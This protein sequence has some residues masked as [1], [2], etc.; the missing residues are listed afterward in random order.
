MALGAAAPIRDSSPMK[1]SPMMLSPMMVLS[2]AV[3]VSEIDIRVGDTTSIAIEEEAELSLEPGLILRKVEGGRA[4]IAA[5]LPGEFTIEAHSGGKT[6]SWRVVVASSVETGEVPRMHPLRR[7]PREETTP[8][9]FLWFLAV[10]GIVLA[11]LHR[12]APREDPRAEIQAKRRDPVD[13]S[14]GRDLRKLYA[15]MESALRDKERTAEVSRFLDH[16]QSVRFSRNP[17]DRADVSRDRE[18][19]CEFLEEDR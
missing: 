14:E 15:E 9:S 4:T 3:E 5:W 13:L 19:L 11:F 17:A 8:T 2:L 18:R 6:R 10:S 16:C 12:R 1:M 7:P